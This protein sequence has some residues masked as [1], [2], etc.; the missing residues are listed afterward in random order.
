MNGSGHTWRSCGLDECRGLV[1]GHCKK[2]SNRE[3]D[4]EERA[5]GVQG[6]VHLKCG[7]EFRGPK[8]KV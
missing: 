6:V 4:V 3:M 7:E 2:Y 1:A 5:H 8:G